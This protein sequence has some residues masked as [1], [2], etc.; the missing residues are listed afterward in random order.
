[1]DDGPGDTIVGRADDL[2]RGRDRDVAQ[3]V[4]VREAQEGALVAHDGGWPRDVGPVS[5]VVGGLVEP[6]VLGLAVHRRA[7]D[8]QDAQVGAR[9]RVRLIDREVRDPDRLGHLAACELGGL[10]HSRGH[11]RPCRCTR[12]IGYLRRSLGIQICGIKLGCEG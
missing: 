1:V 11:K 4:A 5:A 3:E 7:I 12:T 9:S 6:S 2:R 10:A 8:P